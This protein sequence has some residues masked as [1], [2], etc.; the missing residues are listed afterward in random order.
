M[1]GPVVIPLWEQALRRLRTTSG[2]AIGFGGLVERGTLRLTEFDGARGRGME[3]LEVRLGR[4]LGGRVWAERSPLGVSDYGR[5]REISHHYDRPVLSEGLR[6]VVA[7]P[8]LVGGAVRGVVYAGAR[9]AVG[10]GDRLLDAVAQAGRWLGR[11]L[12]VEDE[13]ARRV[14]RR[15]EQ[16]RALEASAN[17]R[18]R[19]AHAGL[20]QLQATTTDALTRREVSRL[21]AD[22]APGSV[23][24]GA[25]SL[26]RRELDVLTQV[27]TGAPYAEVAERL[28]IAPQTVKSYMRDLIATLGVHSRHEAVVE[29][30]RRGLLP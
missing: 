20:R 7:A 21:L 17:E 28:G 30:R 23:D 2:A 14:G 15:T 18:L 16:L 26:T 12:A 13:V 19:R 8:V 22:L 6:S 25:P 27:A 29:A 11:E 4:G 9:E 10:H 24:E 3:G 1:D 5:A